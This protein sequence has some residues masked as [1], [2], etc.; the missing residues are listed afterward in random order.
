MGIFE[1]DLD[2]IKLLEKSQSLSRARQGPKPIAARCNARTGGLG[3][4]LP[5]LLKIIL[6]FKG[7]AT[8][9]INS[10]L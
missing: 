3:L 2:L 6:I 4:L 1:D 10:R 5:L 7:R 9:S 8:D